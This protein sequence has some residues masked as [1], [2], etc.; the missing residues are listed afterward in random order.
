MGITVSASSPRTK[1]YAAEEDISGTTFQEELSEL[2]RGLVDSRALLVVRQLC[3]TVSSRFCR[4][5]LLVGMK[6][7]PAALYHRLL[8]RLRLE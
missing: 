2:Q 6:P 5:A 7:V 8:A 3:S 4:S 1:S